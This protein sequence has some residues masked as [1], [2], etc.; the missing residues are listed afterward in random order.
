MIV[1]TLQNHRIS[2]SIRLVL[3]FNKTIT[4]YSPFL[5][6]HY[7]RF[8]FL[9]K[10]QN[11]PKDLYWKL[12]NMIVITL[13]NRRISVLIRLIL[14]FN[15]TITIYSPFLDLHYRRFV[16]WGKIQNFPKDLYWLRDDKKFKTL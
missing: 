11:F 5:A 9:G 15:K 6:L 16:F 13:Q 3:Y 14:Y 1:I 4:I 7:R 10:I 2:V 8:V 12:L